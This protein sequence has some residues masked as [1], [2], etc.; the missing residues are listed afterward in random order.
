MKTSL[1]IIIGII[2]IIL[3]LLNGILG[4]SHI[5][6][7]IFFVY[8]FGSSFL[9]FVIMAL[10]TASK[11]SINTVII[12]ILLIVGIALFLFFIKKKEYVKNFMLLIG[13]ICG[14]PIGGFLIFIFFINRFFITK[15]DIYTIVIIAFI[16]LGVFLGMILPKYNYISGTSKHRSCFDY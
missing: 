8:I 6:K 12:I 4:Y 14:Y 3:D 11:L 16:V 1:R 2:L 10:F 15:I 5:K 13:G 9:F 7:T